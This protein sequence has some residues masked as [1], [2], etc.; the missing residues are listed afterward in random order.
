VQAFARG[1]VG[2]LQEIRAVVRR[3]FEATTYEPGG[4]AD[5]WTGHHERF[6]RIVDAAPAPDVSE[7]G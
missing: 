6:S 5:A 1:R 7:G 3:S 4:D 2:S